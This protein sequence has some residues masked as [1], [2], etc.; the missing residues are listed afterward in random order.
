VRRQHFE[1][2]HQDVEQLFAR[3]FV[4]HVGHIGRQNLGVDV[5]QM[6]ADN[7]DQRGKLIAQFRQRHAGPSCDITE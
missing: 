7:G 2:A 5:L 1:P 6:R 4:G 3:C